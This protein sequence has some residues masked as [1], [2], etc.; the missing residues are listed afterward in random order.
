MAKTT[1]VIVYPAKGFMGS[2]NNVV[3]ANKTLEEVLAMGRTD[4]ARFDLAVEVDAV[5]Y[6]GVSTPQ[7]E[8]KNLPFNKVPWTVVSAL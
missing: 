7:V 2:T 4:R 5:F 3:V 6:C 1:T 8:T